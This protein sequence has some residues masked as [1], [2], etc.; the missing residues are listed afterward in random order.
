MQM[1]TKQGLSDDDYIKKVNITKLVT[2]LIKIWTG[3]QRIIFPSCKG[4]QGS[5][6]NFP[7]KGKA[8]VYDPFVLVAAVQGWLGDIELGRS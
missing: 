2:E 8:D 7:T 6:I 4:I 1:Q 3:L 5:V